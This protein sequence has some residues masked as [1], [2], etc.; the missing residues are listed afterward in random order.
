MAVTLALGTAGCGLW[1]MPVPRSWR[2]NLPSNNNFNFPSTA[3]NQALRVSSP[4]PTHEFMSFH[5]DFQDFPT[6]DATDFPAF[7]KS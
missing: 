1:M 6:T 5:S 3:L 2:V 4:D 7:S